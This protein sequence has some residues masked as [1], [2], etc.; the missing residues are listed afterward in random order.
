MIESNHKMFK[1]QNDA[2]RYNRVW[3]QRHHIQHWHARRWSICIE[4]G[5][6][7]TS[8]NAMLCRCKSCRQRTN[9]RTN[10]RSIDRLRGE[11]R[12]R[13]VRAQSTKSKHTC[14]LSTRRRFSYST[15]LRK[16]TN[17]QDEQK[18]KLFIGFV[19]RCIEQNQI[20]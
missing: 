5:T 8:S 15:T 12:A 1:T 3:Q 18:Q 17:E 16:Q 20:H 14:T 9:K 4:D 10:D 19:S 6:N 11:R 2:G 7:K 13:R